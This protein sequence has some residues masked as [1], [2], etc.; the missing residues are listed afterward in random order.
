M[1]S[2][3]SHSVLSGGAA[4][5]TAATAGEVNSTAAS[6]P[7]RSGRLARSSGGTAAAATPTA[8]RSTRA[9]KN[10]RQLETV[11][12]VEEQHKAQQAQQPATQQEEQHPPAAGQA[13]PQAEKQ[14]GEQH[15]PAAGQAQPQAE[16]QQGEQHPP[17]AG[18]AQPQAEKQQGEQR[19][20]RA[21]RRS[22][23]A[24][25]A[26]PTRS[27]AVASQPDEAADE[28]EGAGGAA[29]EPAAEEPALEADAALVD[30]LAEQ[31]FAALEEFTNQRHQAGSDS[32]SEEEEEEEEE[33]RQ[34]EQG[35]ADG[36]QGQQEEQQQDGAGS[37][38]SSD[39]DSGSEDEAGAGDSV[40]AHL[41][42]QPELTLPGQGAGGNGSGAAARGTAAPAGVHVVRR[43]KDG[44]HVPPPD[45][46]LRAK[47]ARTERPDT[48]GKGWFDLPATQI[49]DE[50]KNDLRMLRLRGALDPKA[51]YKKL[52]ATKFPKYFQM[53]TVVESAADFYSARLT[54]KQRKRTL[55]EEVMADAHLTEA[56]K[57]RFNKLQEERSYWSKKPAK[58]TSNE[59]RKKAHRRP[60]H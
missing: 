34:Q 40:P 54:K 37:S 33:G 31:M 5:D 3:R 27:P 20:P 52:D 10:R 29:E 60:K 9:P 19:S 55:T 53:G 42:W 22:A 39:D 44:L 56:R 15:P 12:E 7:R 48:A 2:T 24:A 58:K 4:A 59:R 11:K 49:T 6:T 32:G 43:G 8:P 47:A 30:V 23:A 17:A 16:K 45:E 35:A 57:K 25:K 51:H 50:V 38:S 26:V 41:R 13:Q 1:V 14:Q 21:R 28:S 36:Q 46:R 18:Q